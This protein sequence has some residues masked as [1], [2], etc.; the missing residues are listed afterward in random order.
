MMQAVLL[1]KQT[2]EARFDPGAL[3]LDG[4]NVKFTTT[5]Q[6]LFRPPAQRASLK[7]QI[8]LGLKPPESLTVEFQRR[9]ATELDVERTSLVTA[10]GQGLTVQREMAEEAIKTLLGGR[11]PVGFDPVVR[12][13]RAFLE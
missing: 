11:L 12:R 6:L 3:L 10:D 9:S 5:D 4:P 7:M 13:N 2:L 1:L 8:R